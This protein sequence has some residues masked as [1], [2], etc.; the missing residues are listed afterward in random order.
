MTSQGGESGYIFLDVRAE[1]LQEAL[2]KAAEEAKNQHGP[3]WFGLVDVR[4]NV[5]NPIRDYRIVLST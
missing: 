1:S 3:G 5:E 4:F 2:E